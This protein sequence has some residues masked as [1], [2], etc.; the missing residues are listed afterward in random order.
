MRIKKIELLD[1][2]MCYGHFFEEEDFLLLKEIF[3]DWM[4]INEK[5]KHLGQLP[6][7]LVLGL[8]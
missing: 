7:V 6:F 3:Q 8:V 2:T 5:L 1:G 4:M